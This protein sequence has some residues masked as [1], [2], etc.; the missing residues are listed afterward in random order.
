MVGSNYLMAETEREKQNVCYKIYDRTNQYIL[1]TPHPPGCLSFFYTTVVGQ[2]FLH[3]NAKTVYA[4]VIRNL[5]YAIKYK[6]P[7]KTAL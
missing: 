4:L 5:K 7:Y 6:L 3:S 1:H 2:S